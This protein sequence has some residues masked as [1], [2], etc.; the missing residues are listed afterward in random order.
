MVLYLYSSQCRLHAEYTIIWAT[1]G[2]LVEIL[3]RIWLVEHDF[4]TEQ[5]RAYGK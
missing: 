5:F 2:L 4:E 3:A 1:P